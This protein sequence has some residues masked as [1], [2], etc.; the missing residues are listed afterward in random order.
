MRRCEILFCSEAVF[1]V[2]TVKTVKTIEPIRP[3][4]LLKINSEFLIIYEFGIMR[5]LHTHI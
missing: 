3:I 5:L 1:S 4:K 2:L